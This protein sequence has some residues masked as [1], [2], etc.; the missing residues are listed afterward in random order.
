MSSPESISFALVVFD[1]ASQVRPVGTFGS[2]LRGEQTVIVGDNK[3]LPSTNFFDSVLNT[4]GDNFEQQ[5]S[6]QARIFGPFR[7]QGAAEQAETGLFFNHLSDTI[8]HRGE[9][10][11]ESLKE[12]AAEE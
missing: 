4:G 1:E 2:I 10:R 5:A 3:Q 9:Q 6:D 12:Q 8:Y 7:S 11:M